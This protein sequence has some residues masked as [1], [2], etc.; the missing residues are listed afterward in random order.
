[1]SNKRN[2]LHLRTGMLYEVFRRPQVPLNR[3]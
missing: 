3:H 2:S 1:V